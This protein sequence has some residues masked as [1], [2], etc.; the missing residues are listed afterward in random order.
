[1][2][3]QGGKRRGAETRAG[4][5]L[6]R[7]NSASSPDQPGP[8]PAPLLTAPDNGGLSDPSARTC[9]RLK[10]RETT[11]TAEQ[12]S[13]CLTAYGLSCPHW[14]LR[15]RCSPLRRRKT[16]AASTLR[17]CR[18]VRPMCAWTSHSA[19]SRAGPRVRPETRTPPATAPSRMRTMT[20]ILTW[21]LHRRTTRPQTTSPTRTRTGLYQPYWILSHPLPIRGG[22]SNRS[23]NAH[24]RRSSCLT[25]LSPV[26]LG[27]P[28]PGLLL[29]NDAPC[30]QNGG[31]PKTSTSLI[32][33]WS[34][35]DSSLSHLSRKPSG[36]CV[37]ALTSQR[38]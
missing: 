7:L 33:Q 36:L 1:M 29:H 18:A 34:L 8:S 4:A 28:P 2:R 20:A 38:R 13:Q 14:P 32:I 35:G 11:S 23:R 9:F 6:E 26:L 16:L 22:R 30:L 31:A 27:L 37:F 19:C 12:T 10:L 25:R 5:L 3:A 21:A 17:T 24:V 15:T